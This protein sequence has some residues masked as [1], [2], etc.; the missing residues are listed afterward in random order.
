MIDIKK[1]M[2]KFYKTGDNVGYFSTIMRKVF[3][4]I[5]QEK[6]VEAMADLVLAYEFSVRFSNDKADKFR[7][8]GLILEVCEKF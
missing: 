2:R 4:R 7:V 3:L 5:E 1:D 8:L 6:N